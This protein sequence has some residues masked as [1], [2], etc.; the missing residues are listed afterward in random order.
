[1]IMINGA[2][3]CVEVKGGADHPTVLLVGRRC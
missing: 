2:E 3:S 1:M